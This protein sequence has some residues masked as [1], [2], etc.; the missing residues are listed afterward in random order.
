MAEWLTRVAGF[1]IEHLSGYRRSHVPVDLSVPRKGVLHTTEG[2]WAGSLAVFRSRGTPTFMVGRD[3]ASRLRLA[4]F[5]PL[6]EMALTLVDRSGGVRTNRLAIVQIE[7]VG[8]AQRDPWLPDEATTRLLAGLMRVCRE[9]AGIPLRRGG[10]GSRS[11]ATWTTRAGWFGHSEVPENDHWDPGALQWERLFALAG[12]AEREEDDLETFDRIISFAYWRLVLKQDPAKRPANLPDDVPEAWWPR[13]RAI[14]RFAV[15]YGPDEQFVDW[16]RWLI[17]L[18]RA[19]ERPPAPLPIPP[20]WWDGATSLHGVLNEYAATLVEAA[21][22][23]STE[24]IAALNIRVEELEAALANAD[25]PD[26]EREQRAR[27]VM[28]QMVAELAGKFG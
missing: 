26:H 10:D 22:Q 5:M 16:L 17:V 13:V 7:I 6:G 24:Q 2:S 27:A 23:A 25:L 9:Q 1:P 20:R 14:H 15:D 11:P 28:E 8:F 4:Q 3:S 12:G 19:G 21:R 18:A